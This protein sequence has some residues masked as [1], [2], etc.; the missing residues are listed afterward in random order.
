ML[1]R[2]TLKVNGQ[3]C[4][5]GSDQTEDPMGNFRNTF[6]WAECKE[7]EEETGWRDKEYASK[8]ASRAAAL[9]HRR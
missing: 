2:T 3:G 6:V 1:A 7:T 5:D 4:C 8:N 9:N